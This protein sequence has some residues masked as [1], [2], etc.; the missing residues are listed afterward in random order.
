MSNDLYMFL[1]SKILTAESYSAMERPLLLWVDTALHAKEDISNHFLCQEDKQKIKKDMQKWLK[2][3]LFKLVLKY[4]ALE[5][6]ETST[7]KIRNAVYS[8]ISYIIRYAHVERKDR[9]VKVEE[10]TKKRRS[11]HAKPALPSY[12]FITS[13]S[14]S[15]AQ[16]ACYTSKF[17][18]ETHTTIQNLMAKYK[19]NSLAELN[20]LLLS[21]KDTKIKEFAQEYSE[22]IS[23]EG[24]EIDDYTYIT[25]NTQGSPQ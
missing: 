14:D 11:G 4:K 15:G 12:A 7:K 5:E 9:E 10:V 16:A 13:L 22:L 2:N 8:R 24:L 18:G 21:A 17:N 20:Y 19:I 25:V 1:A 3:V 23:S 6:T